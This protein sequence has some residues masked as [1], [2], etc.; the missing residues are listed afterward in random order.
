MVCRHLLLFCDGCVPTT[1]IDGGTNAGFDDDNEG[2]D[3]D[4]EDDDVLEEEEEDL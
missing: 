1:A 3:F 4:L 2:E